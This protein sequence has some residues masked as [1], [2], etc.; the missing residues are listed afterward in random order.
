MFW[1]MYTV[2]TTWMLWGGVSP[3]PIKK[4]GLALAYGPENPLA[5]SPIQCKQ[6]CA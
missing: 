6:T 2:E 5:H 4:T 1:L 3:F